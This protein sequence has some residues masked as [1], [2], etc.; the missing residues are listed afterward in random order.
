MWVFLENEICRWRNLGRIWWSSSTSSDT[1]RGGGAWWWRLAPPSRSGLDLLRS[2]NVGVSEVKSRSQVRFSSLESWRFTAS[3]PMALSASECS[4]PRRQA[5]RL[6]IDL[7]RARVASLGVWSLAVFAVRY[8]RL[9]PSRGSL[10]DLPL[11][12][13]PCPVSRFPDLL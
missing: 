6:A 13:L 10:V 4:V 3:L 9:W 2:E 11:I 1:T 7:A 8:G 5:L 12:R